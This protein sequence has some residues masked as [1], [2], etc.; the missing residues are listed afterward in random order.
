MAWL[1]SGKKFWVVLEQH[2]EINQSIAQMIRD[3]I[4]HDR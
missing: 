3:L 1:H 2:F 4:E